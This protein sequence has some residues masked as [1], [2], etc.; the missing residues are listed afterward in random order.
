MGINDGVNQM[1]VSHCYRCTHARDI[2]S[3]EEWDRPHDQ[4]HFHYISEIKSIHREY[5]CICQKWPTSLP[6]INPFHLSI[7]V[8]FFASKRRPNNP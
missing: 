6:R 1:I 3:Q 2:Q 8:F 5:S 7:F 4:L